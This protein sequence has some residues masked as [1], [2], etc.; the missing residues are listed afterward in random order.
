MKTIAL[1][2]LNHTVLK[3]WCKHYGV[4]MDRLVNMWVDKVRQRKQVLFYD[5]LTKIKINYDKPLK[6]TKIQRFYKK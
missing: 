2:E 6:N 1:S 5:D 4:S 3:Q